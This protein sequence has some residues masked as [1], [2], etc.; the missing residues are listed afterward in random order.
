MATTHGSF[1]QSAEEFQSATNSASPLIGI[2]Q[3]IE[4]DPATALAFLRASVA[5]AVLSS[6]VFSIFVPPDPVNPI[7][8]YISSTFFPTR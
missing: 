3:C 4:V 7:R 1:V 5:G 8:F 6:L 2:R